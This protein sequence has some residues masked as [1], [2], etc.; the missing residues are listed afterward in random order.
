[1]ETWTRITYQPI[2]GEKGARRRKVLVPC[3]A[4]TEEEARIKGIN[5]AQRYQDIPVHG[6]GWFKTAD[7]YVVY[8]RKHEHIFKHHYGYYY[9]RRFATDMGT[10]YYSIKADKEKVAPVIKFSVFK[11]GGYRPLFTKND[12]FEKIPKHKLKVFVTMYVQMILKGQTIDYDMLG[13]VIQASDRKPR[14]TATKAL[15]IWR[16]QEMIKNELRAE[17]EKQGITFKDVVNKLEDAYNVAKSK[18]DAQSM[19]RVAENYMEVFKKEDKGGPQI[20]Q[21]PEDAN[22]EDV[23]KLMHEGERALSGDP[24]IVEK[25]ALAEVRSVL[26]DGNL[27]E[28]INELMVFPELPKVG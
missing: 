17:L 3:Y 16:V 5:Y 15:K 12:Y 18:K 24:L 1:M 11:A 9:L 8:C 26:E 2:N 21:L 27:Q 4:Y 7:N 20:P 13:R 14:I 28:Q 6:S 23:T 25:K 10:W 19:I 22:Y